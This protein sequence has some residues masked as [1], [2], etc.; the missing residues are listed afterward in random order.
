M[1]Q[2]STPGNDNEDLKDALRRATAPNGEAEGEIAA[3]D[4][5]VV[6]LAEKVARQAEP[7]TI[8]K[9]EK[10]EVAEEASRQSDA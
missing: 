8:D 7:R 5:G 6:T 9:E 4:A 10:A 2:A 1:T 3:D